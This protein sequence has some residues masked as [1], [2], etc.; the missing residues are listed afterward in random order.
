ML[1]I[2]VLALSTSCLRKQ[3]T[4]TVK[5][6]A[7]T[8]TFYGL[9]DNEDVY[10]ELISKFEEE[11]NVTIIYKKFTD[12]TAYHDLIVNELA[13]GEGPD[14]F[15][16]HNTW[17]AKDYKKL[18]AAPSNV[19]TPES[20][21]NAFVEV[22]ADDMII[23]DS[24]NIEQVY[25]A[26]IYVDTLALYYNKAHF[27]DAVPERGRPASTWEGI[28]DDV[29]QLTKQDKSFE[30]FER[31]G[32]AMG[33]HDNILRSFDILMMLFLQHKVN[34]YDEEL[35]SVRF[36]T[37]SNALSAIDLFT[38]FAL[39]SKS[40]YSWNK[41]LSDENSDEKELTAF[42]KGKL[43]MLFGY[44][45]AYA[46]IINEINRL[47]SENEET[48]DINDIKIQAV[49]QLFD[50]ESS[51]ETRKTYASYFAP[52]VSRTSSNPEKAWEFIANLVSTENESLIHSI[53]HRPSSRRSLLDSE[54]QDPIYGAFAAQVGYAKSIPMSDT[55]QYRD[56]F[57]SGIESILNT[58]S[59]EKVLKNIAESIQALIPS[60]GIR[61]VYK[62]E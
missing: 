7:I 17:F 42:A 52:V 32:I 21:R 11:N 56:I 26:P 24:D 3:Q 19:V 37:D 43:S 44:S 47:K 31:S 9:Y 41:Y 61:P 14:I 5:E 8:L 15:M 28:K 58:S 13:E 40:V 1:L 57:L 50:P 60:N 39:P 59:S 12:P 20:F 27:E 38:S 22:A 29:I 23:P 18:S 36:G 49:P 48:I 10:S 4:V 55:Y 45:Y 25:G 30:R 16:L 6:E 46:D 62:V 34:F 2:A 51:A 54:S 35:Q 53:T 33:R